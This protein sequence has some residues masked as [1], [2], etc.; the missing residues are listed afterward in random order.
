MSYDT[1]PPFSVSVCESRRRRQTS[2]DL[3]APTRSSPPEKSCLTDKPKIREI[4]SPVPSSRC[5]PI[6][7]RLSRVLHTT[8]VVYVEMV[9]DVIRRTRSSLACSQI[10]FSH[11]F[12]N[13]VVA[14]MSNSKFERRHPN[15][16]TPHRIG[17]R[18]SDLANSMR[19]SN[20][21]T[22]SSER[23]KSLECGSVFCPRLRVCAGDDA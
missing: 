6:M 7:T 10:N 14:R 1:L 20:V 15:S 23:T 16:G 8:L 19:G 12:A 18:G 5:T 22:S 21:K 9:A 13:P 11:S 17:T 3:V 4:S 2:P